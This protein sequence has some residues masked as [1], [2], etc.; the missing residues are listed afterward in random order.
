MKAPFRREHPPNFAQQRA[1]P[2]GRLQAVHSE[3]AIDRVVGERQVL[4]LDEHRQARPVLRPHESALAHG[5]ESTETH[6]L[7]AE[8]AKKRRRKPQTYEGFVLDPAPARTDAMQQKAADELPE[9][10]LIEISNLGDVEVH[11]LA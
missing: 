1:G 10:P 11:R 8:R 4:L 2:L 3:Q 9:R 6:G 5:H 7:A